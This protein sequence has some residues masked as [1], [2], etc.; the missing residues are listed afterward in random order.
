MRSAQGQHL[1]IQFI[2]PAFPFKDQT[3]FRSCAPARHVDFGEIALLARLH[4]IALAIYQI[5]NFSA[6]WIIVSDSVAYAP[7][8]GIEVSEARTYRERLRA[9]RHLLNMNRTVHILDLDDMTT[10]IDGFQDVYSHIV[11]KLKWMRASGI[12]ADRFRVLAR[13]M[14]WNINTRP[15]LEKGRCSWEHLWNMLDQENP[16][17][18]T[19]VAKEID[20]LSQDA[21]LHYAAH[22]LT[23]KHLD[24]L[25]CCFPDAIRATVHPK[26]GQVAIPM[27][28]ETFP[29]NGTALL[30]H[31]RLGPEAVQT[32]P[33][34]KI[35]RAAHSIPVYLPG[36]EAP[37]FF[38]QQE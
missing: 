15:Y 27:L 36:A 34:Y 22:N 38:L 2:L 32:V 16:E 13:G 5:Y 4:I 8:F 1:P 31:K 24:L 19:A 33:L 35:L 25:R 29:W 9:Y 10:R 21:G 14:K 26:P 30:A 3:P 12:L 17:T 6:E 7:L 37:F 11:D 18:S 23:M 20:T 28:G